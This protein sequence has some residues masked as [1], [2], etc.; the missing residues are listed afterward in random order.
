M[1]YQKLRINRNYEQKTWREQEEDRG[2]IK[3][4]ELEKSIKNLQKRRGTRRRHQVSVI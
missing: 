2:T 1:F 4:E 3:L